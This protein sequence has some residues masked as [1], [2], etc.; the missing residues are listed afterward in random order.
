MVEVRRGWWWVV[1]G[2]GGPFVGHWWCGTHNGSLRVMPL[3]AIFSVISVIPSQGLDRGHCG[4]FHR[5]WSVA[6]WVWVEW[7]GWVVWVV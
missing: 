7:I 4:Q 2:D 1:V 6:V 3:L 5:Q